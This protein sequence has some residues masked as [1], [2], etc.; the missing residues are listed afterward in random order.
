MSIRAAVYD[1]IQKVVKLKILCV[2]YQASQ[3]N[4]TTPMPHT[5]NTASCTRYSKKA[6]GSSVL[7]VCEGGVWGFIWCN[8]VIFKTTCDHDKGT[9]DTQSIEKF[10]HFISSPLG[11]HHHQG[12]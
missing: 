6:G 10:I 2:N 3:R 7:E 11:I 4:S 12:E 1:L 8:G 5:N 9:S